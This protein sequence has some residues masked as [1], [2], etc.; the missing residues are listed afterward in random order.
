MGFLKAHLMLKTLA[1]EFTLP[2]LWLSSASK[3]PAP[4]VEEA[5]TL[6]L[7]LS[8]PSRMSL[9]LF[10]TCRSDIG[11][12]CWGFR[13]CGWG[14]GVLWFGGLVGGKVG[15]VQR[16]WSKGWVIFVS[17]TDENLNNG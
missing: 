4:L 3:G 11:G 17:V 2:T 8:P 1:A 15:S 6:G 10:K 14:H 12:C 9:I 7:I 16:D 5:P 13:V